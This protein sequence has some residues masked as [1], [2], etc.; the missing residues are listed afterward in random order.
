[1][2]DPKPHPDPWPRCAVCGRRDHDPRSFDGH[3]YE[4]PERIRAAAR[5]FNARVTAVRAALDAAD[6]AK[7]RR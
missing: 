7:A 3:A 4:A 2:T 1:M 6:A 5:D